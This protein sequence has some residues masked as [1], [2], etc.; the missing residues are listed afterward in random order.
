MNALASRVVT[1]LQPCSTVGGGFTDINALASHVLTALQPCGTL[2]L[3]C[4]ILKIDICPGNGQ[5]VLS[6]TK[7]QFYTVKT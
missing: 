2:L 1:A 5:Q 3:Q 7:W 4:D 6:I